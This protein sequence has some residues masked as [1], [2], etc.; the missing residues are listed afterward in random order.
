MRLIAIS[1]KRGAGKDTLADCLVREGKELFGV[2]Y[3]AK[4]S[5]ADPIKSDLIRHFDCDCGV[6]YGTN[7]QKELVEWRTRRTYRELMVE[8]GRVYGLLEPTHFARL[9]LDRARKDNHPFV[10]VN[11]LR[12]K[13]EAEY[14]RAHCDCK[15]VRLTRAENPE[16][17]SKVENS[18]DGYD[19]FDLVIDNRKQNVYY[20]QNELEK[21]LRQWL[22]LKGG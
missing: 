8:V 12:M 3:V 16:D 5:L 11:D 20:P 21:A 15:L 4:M 18:L 2:P 22:W 17:K 14:F 10:V 19:G 7:A 13:C 1:G 9:L 6:L